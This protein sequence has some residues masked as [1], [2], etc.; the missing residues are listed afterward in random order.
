LYR[1]IPKDFNGYPAES[2]AKRF[3]I[4]PGLM[5]YDFD[6]AFNV[7]LAQE[8]EKQKE[9][10]GKSKPQGSGGG[11]YGNYG[12]ERNV[13]FSGSVKDWIKSGGAAGNAF[14][15]VNKKTQG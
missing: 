13:K 15:Q 12:R 10:D 8:K 11:S 6:L 4:M 7:R 9:E 5:A 14:I 2:P 1:I 3:E